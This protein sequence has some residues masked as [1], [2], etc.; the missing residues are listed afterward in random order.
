[1]KLKPCPKCQSVDLL[2]SDC[3]YSSFNVAYVECKKCGLKLHTGGDAPNALVKWNE[4]C[5]NPVKALM[6]NTNKEN[7]IEYFFFE[8]L[9]KAVKKAKINLMD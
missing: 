1:M 9:K 7:S 6:K 5:S 3:G 2:N 4:I 8:K